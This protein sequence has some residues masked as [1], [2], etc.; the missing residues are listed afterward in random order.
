MSITAAVL[1][2]MKL[3]DGTYAILLPINTTDEVF[4]DIETN[5]SLTSELSNINITINNHKNTVLKDNITILKSLSS[6]VPKPITLNH[7]YGINMDTEDYI[8]IS[9]GSFIPGKIFI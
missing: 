9:S 6:F 2:R 8:T 7:V 3:D 1:Q 5:K 4:V